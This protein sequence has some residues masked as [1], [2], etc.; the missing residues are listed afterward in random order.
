MDGLAFPFARHGAVTNRKGGAAG[1]EVRGRRGA[2]EVEAGAALPSILSQPAARTRCSRVGLRFSGR[3]RAPRRH[4]E[5][6]T[7]A[8]RRGA[9]RVGGG[10]GAAAVVNGWEGRAVLIRAL[11]AEP[12]P[13][14]K[15]LPQRA[16][17]ETG[18]G[19]A[20]VGDGVQ[21]LP[22][23]RRRL[24]EY[25]GEGRRGRGREGGRNPGLAYWWGEKRRASG[26]P[27]GPC[28]RGCCGLKRRCAW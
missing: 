2:P 27:S 16:D 26:L 8:A 20:E 5:G 17:G 18:D 11:P 19:E 6:G 10:A 28:G 25:A 7:R 4:G 1:R 9:G 14:P 24:H 23:L 21:G 12:A 13:Q 15:A 22:R 3:R